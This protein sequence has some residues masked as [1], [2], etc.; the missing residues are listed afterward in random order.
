MPT[1]EDKAIRDSFPVNLN[2]RMRMAG[3]L[4]EGA[5]PCPDHIFPILKVSR[6]PR[7]HMCRKTP[8]RSSRAVLR[9]ALLKCPCTQRHL[10]KEKSAH[11]WEAPE[12]HQMRTVIQGN[13]NDWQSKLGKTWP[14]KVTQ[15]DSRM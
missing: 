2:S 5:G 4:R 14:I 15:T 8:W 12:M 7:P 10:G 6:P 1:L 13:Q 3:Q 9:D 11:T